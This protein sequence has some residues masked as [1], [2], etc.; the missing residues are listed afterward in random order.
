MEQLV[1]HSLK[2]IDT[3]ALIVDLAVLE[4]NLTRMQSAADRAGLQVRPHIKAHKTPE[5][6]RL[7]LD[8]GAIGVTAAKVSE[9]EVFALCEGVSDIFI[10]NEVVG[11]AKVLRLLRLSHRVPR[12]SVAVDSPQCAEPLSE[13]FH[14]AGRTLDVMI[15]IDG[16]AG[17]CG[18][19]TD[20]LLPLADHIA[21]LPGLK[22]VGLM[23]YCPHGYQVHGE[24]EL[25]RVA[26][27][28]GEFL[29]EQAERLQTAG[30]DVERVS[31]GSTPTGLHY[32]RGCGLTEIRPG[33]YC[34]NDRNQVDLG[35]CAEEDVGAAVLTTVISCPSADRALVDAGAKAMGL[36]AS[37][38]SDGYGF[39]VG[40]TARLYKLNDEHGYLDVT[41]LPEHP[42]VGDKLLIVPP[43]LCT[44]VALHDHLWAC[45]DGR[46]EGIWH[47]AA[48]GALT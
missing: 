22:L 33:T 3:P 10:A 46:L 23:A 2:E 25:R 7:Q 37:P 27:R 14:T 24:A 6:A 19:T 36:A 12:L 11:L 18:V 16:G 13:A 21:H 39:V 32:E 4:R 31:G 8:A 35:A 29:A 48:R 38:I 42:K 26:A 5:I 47:I 28:E 41:G 30:F 44:C 43:R 20:G 9:A 45:R 17:R 1:G 34:L 40:T 15:E